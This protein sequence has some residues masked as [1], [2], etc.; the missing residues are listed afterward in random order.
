MKIAICGSM[1]FAEKML[2]IQEKLNSIGHQAFAPGTSENYIGKDDLQKEA[3]KLD[4]KNNQDAIKQHWQIIQASDAILILNFDKNSVENYIGGNSLM[5]I[6]FAHVLDKKIFLY[7]PIPEI[8]YYKT[9]IE[10]VKPVI[11]NGN[12]ENIS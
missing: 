10:A 11:I 8:V 4:E 3:L 12:L 5:E 6:G 9:E 7:N 2:E 1:Q